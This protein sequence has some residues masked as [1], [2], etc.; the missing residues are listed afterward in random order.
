MLIV[1]ALAGASG[2]IIGAFGAHG[3]PGY[4]ES[5]MDD[6]TAIPKRLDQFDVAARYHL[7]HAVA[8]LALTA[9]PTSSRRLQLAAA[10]L[11][12]IGIV[13]FSGSLYVLVATDTPWLGAITPLGGVSWIIAWMVLI[14]CVPATSQ[15]LRD[16]S[17]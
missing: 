8:L 6:P 7:V 4:L 10:S 1:A 17:D 5:V 12:A 13:L 9:L 11:F 15:R 3:L 16:E 2:V 14:G